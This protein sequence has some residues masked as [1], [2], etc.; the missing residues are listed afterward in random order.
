MIPEIDYISYMDDYSLKDLL[1]VISLLIYY[2]E[3]DNPEPET[4]KQY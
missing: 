2:S 3:G 4:H 1:L